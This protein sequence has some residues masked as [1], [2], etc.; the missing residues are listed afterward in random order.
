MGGSGGWHG[1]LCDQSAARQA[2]GWY[3]AA[4]LRLQPQLVR[5][6]VPFTHAPLPHIL[7]V[8]SVVTT[9]EDAQAALRKLAA[10]LR[11]AGVGHA[12]LHDLLLMYASVQVRRRCYGTS[13]QGFGARRAGAKGGVLSQW[14]QTSCSCTHCCS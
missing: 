1:L 12:G 11:A 14:G 7:P 9:L 2:S 8:A 4:G 3:S 10:V 13:V 5:V 6:A